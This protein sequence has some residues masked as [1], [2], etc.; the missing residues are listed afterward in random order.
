METGQRGFIITGNQSYLIPYNDGKENWEAQFN[1]LYQL[2]SD[3]PAQQKNL[4]E[5]K[6]NIENWIRTAGEPTIQFKEQNN[7]DAL[8]AFLRQILVGII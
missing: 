7:T 1:E 5:I 6:D 3:K 4:L 2:M 8:N